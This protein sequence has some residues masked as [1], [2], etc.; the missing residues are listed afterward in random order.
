MAS[1]AVVSQLP[2]PAAVMQTMMSALACQVIAEASRRN[3]PDL[4][5]QRGPMSAA[6]IIAAGQGGDASSLERVLRACAAAGVF[7][8]DA[9]GRFGPNELS[10]A[11]T[12]DSPFSVKKV[13][14]LFGGL[15]FRTAAELPEA[16]A[17]GRPAFKSAYGMAFWEYLNANPKELAEFGEAMKSNS[18]NSL[19]GV[20][21]KCDFSSASKV[22]DIGGGFGHMA[23]ALIEKYPALHGVVMDQPGVVAVAPQHLP[24]TDAS[25]ASR[26]TYVG[27]N[28]FESVPP[29]DVY[30]MKH[31]IHDWEDEKCI[32]LLS[33][34]LRSMQGNGRVIC[35]D[36][37]LPPFGNTGG[38]S[39]K[40]LDI[41]MLTVIT[42]KE[43][44][45]QQW[46]DL[47]RAAGL[48]VRGIT[49]LQDN[50]GTS[51]VEGVKA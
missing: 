2:P 16:V 48:E 17:T 3:I 10:D 41:V 34:C 1:E 29:A 35:V 43:R 22:A 5:K 39:A 28:M 21:E 9:S 45:E 49:P 23:L 40:L 7:T 11:L 13:A 8:E 14:E 47:Y 19:R 32:V 27:G 30:V 24:V 33:N 18:V 31:I 37:V 6:E 36:T 12:S 44:T 25:V 51:I 46:R 42:G 26:L 15:I 50:F 38:I 4:L 20:V